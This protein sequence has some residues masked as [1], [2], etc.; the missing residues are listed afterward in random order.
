MQTGAG[1]VWKGRAY[2]ESV[3]TLPAGVMEIKVRAVKIPGLQRIELESVVFTRL[4]DQRP[5]GC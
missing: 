1:K 5:P 2:R 4:A 3:M